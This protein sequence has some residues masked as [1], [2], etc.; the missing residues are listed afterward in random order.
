LWPNG[1]G[2]WIVMCGIGAFSGIAALAYPVLNA[3]F[4]PGMS[5][6]VNTAVN[7]F[8]FCGAFVIQYAMGAIIDLFPRGATGHYP[9]AAYQTAFG[10]MLSVEFVT[11]L[12]FL[13]PVR[14]IPRPAA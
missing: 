8:F 1:A 11:W 3:H 6:R 12:W 10:L 7:L 2:R 13:V 9:P 14:A 5:G 4:P